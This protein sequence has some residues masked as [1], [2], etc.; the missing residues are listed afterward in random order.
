[1]SIVALAAISIP[2]SGL[3]LAIATFAAVFA[4]AAAAPV[5]AVVAGAEREQECDRVRD[6]ECNQVQDGE[7]KREQE[8]EYQHRKCCLEIF[9]FSFLL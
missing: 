1:M 5:S 8:Q 2:F 3:I 9:C 7:R 6:W 4:A